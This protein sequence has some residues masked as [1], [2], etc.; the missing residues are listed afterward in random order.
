METKIEIWKELPTIP[1]YEISNFG[2]VFDQEKCEFKKPFRLGAAGYLGI[3]MHLNGK[4]TSIGVHRLVYWAFRGHLSSL[5]RQINHI[6]E[7]KENNN[8]E[9][10]ELVT[11][12]QNWLHSYLRRKA[13]KE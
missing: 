6:D 1:R 12:H 9:N 13:E 7:C 3:S 2:R 11:P 5:D 4:K 8:L 10:L